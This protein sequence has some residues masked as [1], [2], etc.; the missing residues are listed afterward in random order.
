MI[1]TSRL[2]M[3]E[4]IV[5]CHPHHLFLVATQRAHLSLVHFLTYSQ[6]AMPSRGHVTDRK[7]DKRFVNLLGPTPVHP[8]ISN[9]EINSTNEVKR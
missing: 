1:L 5:T 9:F 8:Q 2:G 7:T 6:L 4:E 3:E